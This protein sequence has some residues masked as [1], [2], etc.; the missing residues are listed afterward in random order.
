MRGIPAARARSVNRS[1]SPRESL[2]APV[3][4]S[5]W[6]HLATDLLRS[7]I[8]IRTVNP[9]GREEAA[10][11]ELA[12]FGERAHLRTRLIPIAPGRAHAVLDLPGLNPKLEAVVAVAHLD[13]VPPGPGWT[14]PPYSGALEDGNVWGR[15]AID[16]KGV[17][18]VWATILA[19]RAAAGAPPRTLRLIAAAGEEH[20]TGSLGATLETHPELATAWVAFGEGGG[21]LRGHAG[22]WFTAVGVAECGRARQPKRQSGLSPLLAPPQPPGPLRAFLA[23]LADGQSSLEGELTALLDNFPAGA[24]TRSEA[25]LD[26]SA[27]L[28][29]KFG[30]EAAAV[31][32]M[33]SAQ[34]LAASGLG[35][36]PRDQL[37][38]PPGVARPPHTTWIW[39]PNES[40]LNHPAYQAIAATLAGEN[41]AGLGATRPLPVLTRGRT[42]LAWF[43]ARGVPSY[44]LLPLGPDDRPESVHA[45]DERLS[46][47]AI[48]RSLR[49]LEAIALQ[50]AADPGSEPPK[51]DDQKHQPD[52]W[53]AKK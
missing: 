51:P 34:P 21:Y 14:K 22:R 47:T 24:E 23:A 44:G 19:H 16:A 6:V 35:G 2:I 40:P 29:R 27:A 46:I 42:D 28:A 36:G 39:P 8:R 52:T 4:E 11:V 7:L 31:A 12:R 26:W 3:I 48:G 41:A 17:V 50:V 38:V 20:P 45:A 10:A 18:A 5:E 43:R 49:V 9:P 33:T 15:G 32:A 53:E 30:L 25:F 13:V 1:A 37:T